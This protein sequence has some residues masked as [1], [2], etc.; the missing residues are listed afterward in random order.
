MKTIWADTSFCRSYLK[1]RRISTTNGH[2]GY[3]SPG[4]KELG[5]L[6]NNL[7]GKRI[8][9]VGCGAAQ[10][11]IAF[12]K[13]GAL[14]TGI[15]LSPEMI[16]EAMKLAEKEGVRITLICGD[17]LFLSS[18]LSRNQRESFNIVISSHALG[19]VQNIKSVFSQINFFLKLNGKFVFCIS[20]PS[21]ILKKF[22]SLVAP[23][24]QNNSQEE[25]NENIY[26]IN[27]MVGYLSETGFLVERVVEQITRNPSQLSKE[28]RARFPYEP[29]YLSR[30]LD[31]MTQDPHTIIYACRK[32][33][34]T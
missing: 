14:C 29:L 3:L 22:T 30:D 27:E 9:E 31:A 13:Q 32:V 21:Q 26:T 33:K 12:A 6:E 2:Y 34:R 20:H 8:L 1:D 4:E 16:P 11:S 28:E 15:D 23:T 18:L 7:N 17:A 25:W 19:F 10:N 24:H 5:L